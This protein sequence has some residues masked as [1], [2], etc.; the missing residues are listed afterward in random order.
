MRIEIESAFYTW[1]KGMYECYVKLLNALA[2]SRNKQEARTVMERLSS[3]NSFSEYFR[4][5]Y[6]RGHL[7][8]K[9]A[10]PGGGVCENRLV[11]VYF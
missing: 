10:R 5:G 3:Q 1:D 6:G 4:Y 2:L 11:C 8:V 7:W 9:Q